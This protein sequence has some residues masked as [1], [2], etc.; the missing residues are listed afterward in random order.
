MSEEI[1]N[2]IDNEYSGLSEQERRDIWRQGTAIL[3]F[4]GLSRP[5]VRKYL[6]KYNS[7]FTKPSLPIRTKTNSLLQIV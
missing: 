1:S 3:E 6:E 4:L 5:L 7:R 2:D